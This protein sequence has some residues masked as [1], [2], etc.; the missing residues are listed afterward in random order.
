L[1]GGSTHHKAS[2]Y[3]QN[4][5]N[6][7][8]EHTHLCLQWDSK[9]RS[10][11]SSGRR[12]LMPYT[13]R[14][15]CS[16]LGEN[17]NLGHVCTYLEET[18]TRSNCAGEGQRQFNVLTGLH[19]VTVYRRALFKVTSS[20]RIMFLYGMLCI[21]LQ[22]VLNKQPINIAHSDLLH[23]CP[24]EG[25]CVL[26]RGKYEWVKIEFLGHLDL[27]GHFRGEARTFRSL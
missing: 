6:R 20:V 26:H 2:T 24:V 17:N 25:L 7:I 5:T 21:I 4:N 12:R 23:V 3:T 19:G 22:C 1:D 8:N 9:P 13:A 15:L 27:K 16:C 18:E 11:C 14:T 10:Q